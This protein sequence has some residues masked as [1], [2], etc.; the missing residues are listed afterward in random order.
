MLTGAR[1]YETRVLNLAAR[2]EEHGD[3][4]RV[5]GRAPVEIEQQKQHHY[6]QRDNV[7]S[8]GSEWTCA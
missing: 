1:K 7:P 8:L 5:D 3:G 2:L 6:S 4:G